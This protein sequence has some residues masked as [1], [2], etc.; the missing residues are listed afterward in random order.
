MKGAIIVVV[1][2]YLADILLTRRMKRLEREG[3]DEE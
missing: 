2:L 1:V 3:G